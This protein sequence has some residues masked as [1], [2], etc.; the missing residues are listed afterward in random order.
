M[1]LPSRVL[2]QISNVFIWLGTITFF[3]MLIALPVYAGRSGNHNT[4]KDMFT[5]S[6][7]Q[8]SWSNQGLV[9][10]LT[11]LVPCWCISGY[12]STGMPCLILALL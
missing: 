8:T 11:F 3:V 10:L 12:D 1:I 4:A 9:F 6:Y 2:G 7:N 5:S